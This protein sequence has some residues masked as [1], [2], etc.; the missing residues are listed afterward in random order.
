MRTSLSRLLPTVFLIA[1]CGDDPA[2]GGNAVL[3]IELAPEHATL[4]AIGEIVPMQARVLREDGG[5][6]T[7]ADPAWSSSNPRVATIDKSGLARATGDGETSVTATWSGVAGSTTL[8]VFQRVADFTFGTGP[9][10]AV[11]GG[12]SGDVTVEVRDPLGSTVGR[13]TGAVT[14]RIV[15]GSPGDLVGG[16]RTASLEQGRARFGA[17]RVTGEGDGYRLSAAWEDRTATSLPFDVGQGP[18][19]VTLSHSAGGEH[20]LLVDGFSS[21]EFTN[22]HAVVGSGDTVAVGIFRSMPGGND[23]VLVFSPGRRPAMVQG[24]PWTAGL[25]TVAVSLEQ[26]IPLNITVWIVKGPLGTQSARALASID[27]TLTIWTDQNAGLVF[28]SVEI[29][30]ATGDPDAAGLFDVTLCT[31]QAGLENGIGK[32][33]GRINA[34]WVGTVDGGA[35]RGRACP[36]G[37]DHVV[38]AE[39]SGHELLSHEIGHLLSLGHTDAITDLFDQSN[40]MHSAS[41]RRH[42]LTEGQVFRQQFDT[43][44][45]LNRLFGRSS[46]QARSCP[47]TGATALCPAIEVRLWA[48]GAFPPNAG[49]AKA[50]P[51]APSVATLPVEP[52]AVVERWLEIECEMDQNEGL[53]ERMHDL[54]DVAVRELRAAFVDGPRAAFDDD[55]DEWRRRALDGLAFMGTPS[56]ADALAGLAQSAGGAWR[57]EIEARLRRAGR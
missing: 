36:I 6:V 42:Y 20:G 51:R 53:G 39:R 49:A 5:I 17:V 27:T 56:A 7:G 31:S 32:R 33:P 1:A 28:D 24:A 29:V 37:G 22:D 14:L 50:G 38:M 30:D 57:A 54:G 48:D 21:G 12:S 35:D 47:Q 41:N 4:E 3:R 10:D 45:M 46:G 11:T 9:R 55:A 52:H 40:V 15:P 23:E 2:G 34:Y 19:L 13:A 26:P 25:D 18:D 43:N 44:S 16:P 8:T